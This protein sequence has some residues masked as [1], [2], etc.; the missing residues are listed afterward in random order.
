MKIAFYATECG[1]GNNGGARTILK[2]AETL[3]K[4]GH[5]VDT[6]AWVDRFTWFKHR[7]TVSPDHVGPSDYD[8]IIA[9]SAQD[10][11]DLVAWVKNQ[12]NGKANTAWWVRGWE[13]WNLQEKK[14]LAR[15]RSVDK[16]MVNSTWLSNHLNTRGVENTIVRQGI[17]FI[18]WVHDD[19]ARI[20]SKK[21]VI[22]C[23]SHRKHAT[24]NHLFAAE[25]FEHLD[26]KKYKGILTSTPDADF[27][28]ECHIWL[29]PTCLE[30]LHNP[31]ME[32]A[33]CGALVV[34]SNHPRN[35]MV[36]DYATHN[37]AEIYEYGHLID[38]VEAIENADMN[39]RLAMQVRITDNI[40]S[41]EFNMKQMVEVL[42]L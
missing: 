23:L 42:E 38:C 34:C 20:R 25:V 28:R 10:V 11:P 13:T 32:A 5:E 27:Y 41:R 16:L 35:G 15:A 3:R 18:D 36:P 33:L 29:A 24:K 26:P 4:L 19:A 21:F 30:G 9:C 8:W 1:L 7:R 37:T 14:I 22:G 2:S 40:G 17:D 39:K 6:I 31:P 12:S